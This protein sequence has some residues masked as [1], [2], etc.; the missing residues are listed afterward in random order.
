MGEEVQVGGTS[1]LWG[2]FDCSGDADPVDA[3]KVLRHY[4]GLSVAR[5]TECPDPGEPI[6]FG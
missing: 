2:D 4:A 6:V 5:P 3:L 1:R